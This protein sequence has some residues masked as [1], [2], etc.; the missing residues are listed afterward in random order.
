MSILVIQVHQLFYPRARL[1]TSSRRTLLQKEEIQAMLMRNEN[2]ERDD[3]YQFL[4]DT[5]NYY[6]SLLAHGPPSRPVVST[7]PLDPKGKS[8]LFNKTRYGLLK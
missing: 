2:G 8:T 7:E 4:E 6:V 5:G 1:L 3:I